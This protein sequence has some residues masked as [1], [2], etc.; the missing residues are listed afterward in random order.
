MV[1][2]IV[3]VDNKLSWGQHDLSA[4]PFLLVSV[5]EIGFDDMF[6]DLR[7]EVCIL[8]TSSVE[9]AGNAHK[10]FAMHLHTDIRSTVGCIVA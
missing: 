5:D 7:H 9:N 4:H 2:D 1:V 8:L 3:K 6:H 10:I